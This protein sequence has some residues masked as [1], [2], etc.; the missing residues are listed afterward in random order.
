MNTKIFNAS[1]E[2]QRKQN[3]KIFLIID[4]NNSLANN[5]F[6]VKSNI[7]QKHVDE[8]KKL[9]LHI[10]TTTKRWINVIQKYNF[11]KV[12]F[13]FD[14]KEKPVFRK[15]I[16]PSYKTKSKP[17]PLLE[18]SIQTTKKLLDH[19]YLDY[20]SI[21]GYEADDI[22]A[23]LVEKYKK[24]YQIYIWSNDKD[25][26]QLVDKNVSLVKYDKFSYGLTLI[27]EKYIYDTENLLPKEYL[28]YKVIYGDKSNNTPGVPGLY[29]TSLVKQLLREYKTIDNILNIKYPTKKVKRIMV[30]INIHWPIIELNRKLVILVN[31]VNLNQGFRPRRKI[32]IGN[33]YAFCK[34]QNMNYSFFKSILP[35]FIQRHKAIYGEELQEI[36]PNKK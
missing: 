35:F 16:F 32:G 15:E 7:I 23:T 22:I 34:K 9:N 10:Y 1:I 30:N 31:N 21:P 12:M 6:G 33:L 17:K 13:V 14:S 25:L 36:H 24:G 11:D 3:K 20:L 4:G 19:L 2:Q 8:N 26:Y 29:W 5:Y 18:D 28:E 27:D